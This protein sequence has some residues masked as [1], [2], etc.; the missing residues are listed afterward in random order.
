MGAHI[1]FP[2]TVGHGLVEELRELGLSGAWDAWGGRTSL[3]AQLSAWGTAEMKREIDII[4]S[5]P[6]YLICRLQLEQF[7]RESVSRRGIQVRAQI[8]PDKEGTVVVDATGRSGQIAR[9]RGATRRAANRL[10]AMHGVSLSASLPDA[11]AAVQSGQ[12]GWWFA[13]GDRGKAAVMYLST[14]GAMS[15]Q[16]EREHA[17][18]QPLAFA[19]LVGETQFHRNLSLAAMSWLETSSAD[20]WFAVG[21]SALALDPILGSGVDVAVQSARLLRDAVHAQDPHDFYNSSMNKLVAK[22]RIARHRL[23]G[24]AAAWHGGGFWAEHLQ[25]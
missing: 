23:Y 5:E 4:P 15:R 8:E 14:R 20:N 11:C 17:P 24:R 13:V 25:V 9:R 2:M 3:N 22:H 19:S 18:D 7:L 10:V 21:E 16:G 1:D 12:D 6:R